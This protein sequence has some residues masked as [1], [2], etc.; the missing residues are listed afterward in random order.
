M[1][2]QVAI[3]ALD[4]QLF[5]HGEDAILRR[6]GEADLPC[7]ILVRGY[8]PDEMG[9]GIKQGDSKVVMSP[10]E[11][12]LAGWSLPIV[13]GDHVVIQGTARRIEA[14]APKYLGGQLVRIDLQVRG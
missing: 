9:P 13:S 10:T 6:T 3:S 2:P 7:R 4:R 1:T 14:A 5:A 12:T 11:A 8:D